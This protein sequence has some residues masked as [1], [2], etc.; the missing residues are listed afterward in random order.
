MG[1]AGES[2]PLPRLPKAI[3]PV[4]NAVS[5]G[6]S[7]NAARGAMAKFLTGAFVVLIL[8]GIGF[9]IWSRVTDA[10]QEELNAQISALNKQVSQLNDE[11]TRLKGDLAR[12]QSEQQN[13]AAQLE[14]YKKAVAAVK[15]TGKLPANIDLPYPPK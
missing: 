5:I 10:R 15:A 2:H 9:F 4:S 12:V 8:A 1:A 13:L 14:E 7:L 3:P 11:N 6:L